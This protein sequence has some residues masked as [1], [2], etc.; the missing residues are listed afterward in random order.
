MQLS[1]RARV[2]G[3]LVAA[4]SATSIFLAHPGVSTAATPAGTITF[5]EAAGASPNYIFPFM[6]CAYFSINNVNQ[7]QELMFRPL[8]WF[9]VG[10][11]SA[12]APSVSLAKPPQFSHGNRTVT[13]AMKGWRFADGQ[14]VDARSVMFFLNMYRADPTSYCGY[15]ANVGIPDQVISASALA[16]AVTITFA[17]PVD[18][19]W[20]LSNYLSQITPMPNAWDFTA[21]GVRG[22]CAS[23]DFGASTTTAACLNVE[24]YL[25]ATATKTSTYTGSMWQSGV[26]GPWKLTN[27]DNGG[28]V[29]FQPNARYSGPQRPMVRY[30]REVAFTTSLAEEN[31]LQ[32]GSLDIGYV[33]TSVLPTPAP[34]PGVAGANW[35]PLSS[36]YRLFAASPWAFNYAAFNFSPTDPKAAALAQLYI[37][38]ALQTAVDQSGIITRAFR[39]YAFPSYSPLPPSTPTAIGGRLVNP[40]PFNLTAA[41]NLLIGHGWTLQNGVMTC[42]TPGSAANQCGANISVHYT[43]NFNMVWTAGSPS[44]DLA[45][46]N[47]TAAWSS[48]GIIV[49]HATESNDKVIADCGG[50]SGFEICSWAG[51]WSYQPAYFPSGERLFNPTSDFNVGSYSSPQMTSLIGATVT[52]SANLAAYAKYA[53][54]QLPVL[55]EPTPARAIEVIRTLRS[56]VGVVPSP[57]GNFMPEYLHF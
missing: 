54:V 42:T 11:S 29:T 23:G 28:N 55:Y 20:V 39:G 35:G 27:F 32:A 3:I 36:R 5:A 6:G 4:I 40:Y 16:N 18:H 1:R 2:S 19:Q 56:K 26:D 48:I 51:G 33:D 50:A 17:T 13:I 45:F 47:E 24:H 41:K 22:H 52:G 14:V 43:L 7:F 30:V 44:L 25:D 31:R 37:R 21:P 57:L 10:G 12:F 8:Y 34:R 46:A 53:A 38:Q 15:T 49:T 9:G